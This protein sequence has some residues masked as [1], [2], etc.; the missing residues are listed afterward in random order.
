MGLK[1]LKGGVFRRERYLDPFVGL[2][3]NEPSTPSSRGFGQKPISGT[4]GGD[5]HHLKEPTPLPPS[6]STASYIRGAAKDIRRRGALK[7]LLYKLS[8]SHEGRIESENLRILFGDDPRRR[9][10]RREN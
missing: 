4:I 3:A 10:S 7:A 9:I 5:P 6:S 1:S 8:E 2:N